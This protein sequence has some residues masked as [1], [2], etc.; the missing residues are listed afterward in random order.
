MK[1]GLTT[2]IETIKEY[3]FP[4]FC[5]SCDQE[6]EWVCATCFERHFSYCGV[7]CCPVCHVTS[8]NG[9]VCNTCTSQSVITRHIAILPYVEH[10]LIAELLHALKY[11]Y[12]ES[13][14][15]SI[16]CLVEKFLVEFTACSSVDCIVPVP[17]HKKRFA[18][19]GFNQAEKIAQLV[20][21]TAG[22]P[23]LNG[24]VRARKTAQ[25]A[26]LSK[27][28]RE[29]NVEQA[30]VGYR[31]VAGKTILLVDDVFTTGSTMQECARALKQAGAVEVWG[32]S[33]ARG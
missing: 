16:E 23:V 2:T 13:V 20:S 27:H 6:G 19:R 9:N 22:V 30:F 29:Q 3:L 5:L 24:V 18:E 33:I 14:L 21:H 8:P 25:Q 31:E 10:A 17:L 26:T 4:I 11:Q 32:F 1:R 15:S 7:F 12:A 28:E